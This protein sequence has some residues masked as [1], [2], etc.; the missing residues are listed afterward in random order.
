MNRLELLGQKTT[1]E[2]VIADTSKVDVIDRGS[3]IARLEHIQERFANHKPPTMKSALEQRER[4]GWPPLSEEQR[5]EQ[6]DANMVHFLN[7]LSAQ[8]AE[9]K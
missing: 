5:D 3:L 4:L 8:L 9:C 2:R 6:F 7:G 1:S